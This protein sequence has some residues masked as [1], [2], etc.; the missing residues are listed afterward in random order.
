MV[1]L[2]QHV[3]YFEHISTIRKLVDDSLVGRSG[4][5]NSTGYQHVGLLE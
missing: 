4:G 1:L 2:V 5:L 3:M